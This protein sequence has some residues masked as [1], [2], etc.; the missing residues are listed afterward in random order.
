LIGSASGHFAPTGVENAADRL[1]PG[2]AIALSR[3][4]S[5]PDEAAAWTTPFGEKMRKALAAEAAQV[6]L[7]AASEGDF[8]A[9]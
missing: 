1:L 2:G 9:V 4:R 7:A 3:D 5:A 6:T 8:R